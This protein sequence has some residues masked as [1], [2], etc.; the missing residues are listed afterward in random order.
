MSNIFLGDG[1][2]MATEH[3]WG[4]SC[5][6][7]FVKELADEITGSCMIP[8]HLPA[9]E[10]ENIIKRAR[11]WFYKKYEY[12]VQENFFVIPKATFDSTYFKAS[13]TINMPDEVY[14]IFGVHKTNASSLSGDVNFTEG[15][16]SIERMFAGNMYGNAGT[17]GSAEALEYYVINQ[18]FFDLARQILNN[19][20]S[21]DFNRLN[22]ALRFTGE[23]PT[24]DVIL[25]VYETI[26]DCALY[27]DEIF[28]R[29]CA[30]KIKI[31]LGSKLGIFEFQ[32]PGNIAVNADAIQGL[33]ESELES[34][35]EEI[36]GDEGVDW[37]MHS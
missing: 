33:G 16:F 11:K 14:S 31:S 1:T 21:F 29:Y 3:D 28:F 34:V 15:D 37:M 2:E 13:R 9:A 35:I 20:Y 25:E 36:N 8:M 24:T 22:H 5:L 30:A 4:T 12:S 19:P 32:L 26:P 27:D 18:K 23:T 17:A 7:D 10:V 6:A